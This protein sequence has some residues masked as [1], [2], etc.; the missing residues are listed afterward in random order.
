MCDKHL[1]GERSVARFRTLM[2][3]LEPWLARFKSASGTV[4]QVTPLC[5]WERLARWFSGDIARMLQ[6]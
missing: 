5:S 2:P 3:G 6:R 1:S 4:V